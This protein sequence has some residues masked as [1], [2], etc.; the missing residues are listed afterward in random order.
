MAKD[1]RLAA[2]H[3]AQA[4][5]RALGQTA[6]SGLSAAADL[7]AIVA[8]EASAAPGGLSRAVEGRTLAQGTGSW[9]ARDGRQTA[10][11]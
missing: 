3:G 11:E 6:A 10:G 2:L 8:H 1:V 9:V 5:D 4:V 7:A